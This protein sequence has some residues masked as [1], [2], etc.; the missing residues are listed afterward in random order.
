MAMTKKTKKWLL[1]LGIAGVGFYLIKQKKDDAK[2]LE[3]AANAA[4]PVTAP[5]PSSDYVMID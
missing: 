2:V 3:A 5:V 1:W 4:I